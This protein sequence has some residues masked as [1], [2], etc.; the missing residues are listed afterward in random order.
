MVISGED[1]AYMKGENAVQ[2]GDTTVSLLQRMEEC[3]MAL[4][5]VNQRIAFVQGFLAHVPH[6][7]KRAS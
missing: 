1:L 2:R 4:A 6:P 3:G 7:D 5:P